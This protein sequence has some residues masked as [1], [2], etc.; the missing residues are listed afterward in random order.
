MKI[1]IIQTSQVSNVPV[2]ELFEFVAGQNL[3]TVFDAIPFL[4]DSAPNDI[5]ARAENNGMQR[6]VFFE[7]S[8]F[9]R[10]T[11]L[12]FIADWSFSARIDNF[13]ALRLSPLRSMEYQFV[14]FDNPDESSLVSATFQFKMRSLIGV[15]LFRVLV[16]KMMQKRFDLFLEKI[17]HNA[18]QCLMERYWSY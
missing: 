18:D 12:T 2:K 6:S 11:F 10:E 17:C 14:F 1:I 8:S 16:K 7:D 9:A 13:S 15:F 5:L 4:A 3:L